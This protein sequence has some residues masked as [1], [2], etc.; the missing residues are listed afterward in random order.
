MDKLIYKWLNDYVNRAQMYHDK[1]WET[2][3]DF[4]WC[5]D[6]KEIMSVILYFHD[7]ENNEDEFYEG[8]F[9]FDKEKDDIENENVEIIDNFTAQYYDNYDDEEDETDYEVD[10]QN[11][12]QENLKKI[13]M[14]EDFIK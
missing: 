14:F 11:N 8:S 10:F 12:S 4:E 13:K 3:H 6:G 5:N 1:S 9:Q 7:D 2:R